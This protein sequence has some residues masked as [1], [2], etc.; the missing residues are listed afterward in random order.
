MKFI[1]FLLYLISNVRKST[2]PTQF[3]IFLILFFM[4]SIIGIFSLIQVA[5]PFTYIAL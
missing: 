1:R 4:L 5:L 2:S 3:A